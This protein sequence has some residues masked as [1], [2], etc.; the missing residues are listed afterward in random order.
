MDSVDVARVQPQAIVA[1]SQSPVIFLRSTVG[2]PA[3]ASCKSLRLSVSVLTTARRRQ[4]DDLGYFIC[5]SCAQF[6]SAEGLLFSILGPRRTS[7]LV[8]LLS[9]GEGAARAWSN[10]TFR[11]RSVSSPG[12]GGVR[13]IRGF[14]GRQSQ[15]ADGVGTW[16]AVIFSNSQEGQLLDRYRIED[17]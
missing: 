6:G 11:L 8:S 1:I 17:Y 7:E 10:V 3:W 9:L 4:R 15:Y 16:E 13:V 12:V 2:P 5:R 14:G